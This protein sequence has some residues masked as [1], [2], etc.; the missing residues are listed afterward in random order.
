[1][2]VLKH[3][4]HD[5]VLEPPQ[6]DSARLRAAG[7]IILAVATGYC[8]RMMKPRITTLEIADPLLAPVTPLP[9]SP[10][11]VTDEPV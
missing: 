4:H 3:S 11:L 10:G 5:I 2:N 6:K 1:M 8:Y 7:A 9:A